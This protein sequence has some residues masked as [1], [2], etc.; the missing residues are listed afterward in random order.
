M[1][2]F[3]FAG[4]PPTRPAS[5]TRRLAA[6]I[7]VSVEAWPSMSAADQDRVRRL[8]IAPRQV[9]YAG[10]TANA[11]AACD[12]GDP[13]QVVGLAL[14]VDGAIVGFVV[15]KR[16]DAAPDWATPGTAVLSA[17]RVD[18]QHQGRGIGSAALPAIAAWVRGH[19][20]SATSLALT[21]DEE[22][23][24]AI[25][26]YAKAGWCEIGERV[27]GRIGWVRTMARGVRD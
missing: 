20:K 12:D 8:T 27:E 21:V 9:E 25:R 23:V 18:V 24:A 17:L 3:D 26:A 11:V 14:R 10:S 13:K 19:W 1:S 22:N 16:R 4:A 5:S 15:V 6:R 7:A 2:H